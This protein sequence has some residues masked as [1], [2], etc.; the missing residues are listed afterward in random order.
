MKLEK[1]Y[2]PWHHGQRWKVW[3]RLCF[4]VGCP[5]KPLNFRCCQLWFSLKS[6]IQF[7]FWSFGWRI[8][9]KSFKVS[10]IFP[11]KKERLSCLSLWPDDLWP[12][13]SDANTSNTCWRT[14]RKN[15][16]F[17]DNLDGR[18]RAIVFLCM[19]TKVTVVVMTVVMMRSTEMATTAMLRNIVND[20]GWWWRRRRRRKHYFKETEHTEEH[21]KL[22]KNM[23]QQQQQQQIQTQT[24]IL[25]LFFLLPLLVSS[26]ISF[27][28]MIATFGQVRLQQQADGWKIPWMF[29]Q[30]CRMDPGGYVCWFCRV[31]LFVNHWKIWWHHLNNVSFFCSD[32]VTNMCFW[33]L[34]ML[35]N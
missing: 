8:I 27:V 2:I 25:L 30:E 13:I 7:V 32:E 24:Q 17:L 6:S 31:E 21:D 12:E 22:T 35:E 33:H 9:P 3:E 5:L 4:S 10:H 26:T 11:T 28:S 1:S 23:Q 29:T 34:L 16:R 20:D 15:W 14:T 18:G 19:L